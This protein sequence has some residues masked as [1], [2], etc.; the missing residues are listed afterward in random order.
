[1]EI[2]EPAFEV[3]PTLIARANSGVG[4]K[5]SWQRRFARSAAVRGPHFASLDACIA[6]IRS[7][8]V[9]GRRPRIEVA[10]NV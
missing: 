4:I 10:L 6:A 8:H 1:M 5:W 7:S 2:D 3:F 9:D